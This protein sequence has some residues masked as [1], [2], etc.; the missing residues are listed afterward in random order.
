[1]LNDIERAHFASL[2]SLVQ[3]PLV[4]VIDERRGEVGESFSELLPLSDFNQDW[5]AVILDAEI[6]GETL[7]LDEVA[8][9]WC[10]REPLPD[11][12]GEYRLPS[13]YEVLV[14]DVEPLTKGLSEAIQRDFVRQLRYIDHSYHSGSGSTT[15]IR[16][17]PST[18]PL[19]VW[20]HDLAMTGGFPYPYGYVKLDLTYR[21]YIETLLATK[22]TW[23]WQYL[24][25]DVRFR[26]SL[27]EDA[28][29]NVKHM[30]DA[31][32]DIFPE[33]DYAELQQRLEARL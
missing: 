22:G 29:S 8:V 27:L 18:S 16:M 14:Q 32:P 30:L 2:D 1:M 5:E 25:A 9:H 31:F 21:R 3:Q 7:R 17:M 24:F 15:Y 11:F 4:E 28:G 23:G 6:L 33:F 20:Q 26:G 13:P 19:E 12:F 10:T